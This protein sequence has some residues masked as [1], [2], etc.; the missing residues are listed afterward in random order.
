MKT[1][2]IH[3]MAFCLLLG[4]ST[5][6]AQVCESEVET[7]IGGIWTSD[8]GF[9]I[10]LGFN[11]FRSDRWE[12]RRRD[13]WEERR[14]ERWEEER[15][16]E[17]ERWEEERE[18]R[19]RREHRVY[20]TR[21][22]LLPQPIALPNCPVDGFIEREFDEGGEWASLDLSRTTPSCA[23]ACYEETVYA[24]T[25]QFGQPHEVSSESHFEGM[26][27]TATWF[28]NGAVLTVEYNDNYDERGV[29]VFTEL[30]DECD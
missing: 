12:D 19:N 5:A 29:E 1:I 3:T 11:I 2:L 27:Q 25:C 24:Y 10:G 9:E 18:W 16:E 28:I 23:Q 22:I 26:E 7:E 21:R 8:D 14:R 4:W 30:D 15:W 6:N 13:R 17:R 20:Q